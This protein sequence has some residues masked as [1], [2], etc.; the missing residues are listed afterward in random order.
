MEGGPG[1]IAQEVN[2][3]PSV[4]VRAYPG[5]GFSMKPFWL[6]HLEFARDRIEIR[7]QPSS[8]SL[9]QVLGDDVKCRS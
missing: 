6:A 9:C 1:S 3:A 5:H 4:V 8:N 7:F 2:A